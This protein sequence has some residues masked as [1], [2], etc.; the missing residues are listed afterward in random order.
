MKDTIGALIDI[1][2]EDPAFAGEYNIYWNRMN[3]IGKSVSEVCHSEGW[4]LNHLP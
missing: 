2:E 1:L 4:K 3:L